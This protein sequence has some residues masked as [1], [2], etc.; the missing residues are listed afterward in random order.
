MSAPYLS[1]VRLRRDVSAGALA[2]LLVPDDDTGAAAGHHLL[3][4]LFA[5]APDRRR[6]FLW[7][8]LEGEAERV[9]WSC[10]NDHRRIDTACSTSRRRASTFSFGRAIASRSA[11]GPTRSSRAGWVPGARSASTW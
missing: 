4:S 8:A 10:R 5:D 2:P 6:D 1:R 11:C 3:W 9:S 7:R